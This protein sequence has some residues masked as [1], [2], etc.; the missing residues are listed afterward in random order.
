[1]CAAFAYTCGR[2]FSVKGSWDGELADVKGLP[3]GLGPKSVGGIAF[4]G[5]G[6]SIK[7]VDGQLVLGYAQG[8]LSVS[9]DDDTMWQAN[10][11]KEDTNLRMKGRGL[12]SIDWDVSKSA[13]VEGLGAVD[14][15]VSSSR[16][17]GVAVKPDFPQLK[18][19][20]IKAVATSHGDDLQGSL[21]VARE[22][23]PGTDVMYSVANEEGNYNLDELKHKAKVSS[24]L[25]DFTEALIKLEGGKNSAKYNV[26]VSRDLSGLLQEQTDAVI[27]ADNGGVYG[28]LSGTRSIKEGLSSSYQASA[29]GFSKESTPTLTYTGSLAHKYGKITVSRTSGEPMKAALESSVSSGPLKASGKLS[30]VLQKDAPAPS[31]NVTLGR[32]LADVLPSGAEVVIGMDSPSVD[33]VYGKVAAKLEADAATVEYA[34]VGRIKD[35]EHSLKVSNNLGYAKLVKAGDSA[36][37]VQLGY[38]FEA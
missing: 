10:F 19:A 27:G 2:T 4:E 32:D 21:E 13:A 30:Q 37:R 7:V 36:P 22:V 11:S 33:G 31:F 28:A 6:G 25:D 3:T 38:Q 15:N 23:I 34:S 17:F 20:D 14:V 9:V 16:S 35:M 8:P 29:R 1:M 24:K 26:T 12:Y 18:G 5:E